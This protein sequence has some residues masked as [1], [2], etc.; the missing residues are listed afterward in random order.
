MN[1]SPEELAEVEAWFKNSSA[2][3]KQARTKPSSSSPQ[4]ASGQRESNITPTPE[5]LTAADLCGVRQEQ[6]GIANWGP[7][8]KAA[9]TSGK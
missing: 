3:N 7:N 8:Y 4:V 9:S 1:A 5:N 2:L 6:K